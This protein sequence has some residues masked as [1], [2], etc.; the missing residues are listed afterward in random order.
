MFD[1]AAR[2]QTQRQVGSSSGATCGV[3]LLHGDGM[4]AALAAAAVGCAGVLLLHA[5]VTCPLLLLPHDVLGFCC[6]IV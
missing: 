4:S 1:S 5:V 2:G 3:V 6:C